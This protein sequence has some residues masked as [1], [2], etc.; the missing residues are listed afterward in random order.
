[1][2]LTGYLT[3]TTVAIAATI[4]AMAAIAAMIAALIAIRRFDRAIMFASEAEA[5]AAVAAKLAEREMSLASRATDNVV[6]SRM[7]ARA[8]AS[9][10]LASSFCLSHSCATEAC[11]AEYLPAANAFLTPTSSQPSLSCARNRCGGKGGV[12]FKSENP[13]R[14][15]WMRA[16]AQPRLSVGLNV[17]AAKN[18]KP[19]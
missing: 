17:A 9:D 6:S 7:S 14:T 19:S 11:C 1:M 16:F 4:A 3:P 18:H 12:R 13:D 2:I 8:S 15:K 10:L 5:A